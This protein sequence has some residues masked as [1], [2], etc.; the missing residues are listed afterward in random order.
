MTFSIMAKY[1]YADC[2]AYKPFI[3]S[4]IMQNVIILSV[5]ILSG[6]APAFKS[7]LL[8]ILGSCCLKNLGQNTSTYSE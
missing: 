4:V 7:K 8:I 6:M 3:L 5:V 1:V 2:C